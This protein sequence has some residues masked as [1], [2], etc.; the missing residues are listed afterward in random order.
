[1]LAVSNGLQKVN[2][3]SILQLP[4]VTPSSTRMWLS[5]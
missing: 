5:I 1:M 2:G 3:L 4:T